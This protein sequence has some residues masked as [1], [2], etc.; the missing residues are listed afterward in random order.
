[1]Q[2]GFDRPK[3][4]RPIILPSSYREALFCQNV[5]QKKRIF[6]EVEL[7]G[8]R[9]KPITEQ[10]TLR[11]GKYVR[12]RLQG[13]SQRA[14]ALKARYSK[15][16]AQRAS[17]DIEGKPQVQVG[18]RRLLERRWRKIL[19]V[20]EEGALS[21]TLCRAFNIR[22]TAYGCRSLGTTACGRNC[23]QIGRH[24]AGEG[25]GQNMCLLA[26][27]ICLLYGRG[28]RRSNSPACCRT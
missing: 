1:M 22:R 4:D 6:F 12:Y 2:I 20:I 11:Q 14:S 10:L 28:A 26:Q 3:G 16:T 7:G 15:H 5:R 8:P 23:S 17:L 24:G 25:L 27:S 21:T 9:Q 13:Y 18:L 19:R